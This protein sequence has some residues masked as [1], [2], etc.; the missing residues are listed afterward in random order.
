MKTVYVIVGMV[1]MLLGL[2]FLLPSNTLTGKI[3]TEKPCDGLGCLQLCDQATTDA[4]PIDS[5]GKD[6][7]CC[8]THWET[9]VCDYDFNCEKIREYSLYQT[10]ETYQDS[11]R[12]QPSE[13]Q[14]SFERFFLPLI[15]ILVFITFV[16]F[17]YLNP[18]NETNNR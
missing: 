8:P 5:C 10:L 18:E 12:E 16:I 1:A 4:Y 13:V 6:L 11:V 2:T 7:V 15:I 9:G 14:P 17:K 3:V